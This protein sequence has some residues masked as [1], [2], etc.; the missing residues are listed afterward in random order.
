[1]MPINSC[2]G[3]VAPERHPGCH[4]HCH[5]YLE[6]KAEHDRLKAIHDREKD[7]N[8][9]IYIDRNSKVYK[10]MRDRRCKKV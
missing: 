6:A 9:G 5:K 2:K 4:D 1:M 3:C 8:I 10:A 7:I